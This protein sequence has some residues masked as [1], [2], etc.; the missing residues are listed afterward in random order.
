VQN[1][2]NELWA[3]F[4]FLMPNFLG[5][6]CDFSSEFGKPIMKGQL[7][8]ASAAAINEGLEKLKLLHQQCLPFVLRREKDQVLKELP[9]KNVSNIVVAMSELQSKI[10]A[11]FRNRSTAG[12]L[13]KLLYVL[14]HQHDN[15]AVSLDKNVMAS[16]LFLRLLCTHP[17]LVSTATRDQEKDFS[18]RDSVST[19]GKLLALT[20]LL[21][22]AGIYED[23]MTAA[24][25]DTSLVYC[26]SPDEGK[27]LDAYECVL[28]S[29][30]DSVDFIGKQRT[31]KALSKCIIFAQYTR[32]LDVVED[33]V[34]KVHMPSLRYVRLDGKVPAEQRASLAEK[35]N[36]DPTTRV[37]L[38]TSKVGGLGLNLTG[39]FVAESIQGRFLTS[40]LTLFVGAD[41]VIFLEN[42]YNP[43]VDLQ[44][45]DRAHRLGQSK[46]VNV[47]NFVTKNSIEE[48]IMMLQKKKLAM[49]DAI[50]NT[51]NSTLYSMGT[52]KLLDLFSAQ[53]EDDDD[54]S[55]AVKFDLDALV[56][57]FKDDYLS[58][59]VSDFLRSFAEPHSVTS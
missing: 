44:A 33:L 10:Y 47:Y 23:G 7:P 39:T 20:D 36:S 26:E 45:M 17:C 52:D 40:S 49:V 18:A 27:H 15:E 51:D 11:A 41:T 24:D 9:P 35:F 14:H 16:L 38:A 34:F 19:S 56:E 29:T 43:F 46:V 12:S 37:I 31:A 57:S 21:I 22:S 54:D 1:K 42:D 55:N 32:S 8:G 2:V 59:S 25:N 5:S 30:S 6:S 13:Q 53:G 4:D 58:L 50:V 48:S 3:T 28:E